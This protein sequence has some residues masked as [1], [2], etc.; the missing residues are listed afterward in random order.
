MPKQKLKKMSMKMK[1]MD[2]DMSGTG[3]TFK[4]SKKR[5]LLK[6]QLARFERY[7]SE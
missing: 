2:E 1:D 6:K 5:K 4:K 3:K 7:E